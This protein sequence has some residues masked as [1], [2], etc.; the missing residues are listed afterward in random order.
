MNDIMFELP[1]H[2]NTKKIVIDEDIV[3]GKNKFSFK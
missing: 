3:F 1:E 2:K